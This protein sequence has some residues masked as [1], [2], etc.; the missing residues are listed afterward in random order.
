MIV[1][2]LSHCSSSILSQSP[3]LAA[4]FLAGLTGGFTHCL[5]MC[6]PFVACQGIC[7]TKTCSKK[8]DL[9]HAAF[10]HMGRLAS[11]GALGFAAALLS[12]QIASSPFWPW[13][14][15]TMLIIAGITFL[16]SSFPGCRHQFFSLSSALPFFRGALLGFLPCGMIYAALMMAA[17]TADPLFGMVA[18][19]SFVFGTIPA[20]I[21]V[22]MSAEALNFKWHSFAQKAGRAML[23]FNGLSLMVMAAYMVR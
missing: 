12:K 23:A 17:A 2:F 21:L 4:F 16:L 19:W 1:E 3:L 14:S 5:A 18:M 8:M 7:Q 20:L 10:Y 9:R 22:S 6:G 15:A 11:Y 13:L